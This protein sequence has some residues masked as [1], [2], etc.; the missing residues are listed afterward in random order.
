MKGNHYEY[1]FKKIQ[2]DS[3]FIDSQSSETKVKYL[4]SFVRNYSLRLVQVQT[5]DNCI[6]Y[7][8]TLKYTPTINLIF[9]ARATACIRSLKLIALTAYFGVFY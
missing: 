3:S 2:N 7:P 5:D 1:D 8:F 6:S 9:N 4:H